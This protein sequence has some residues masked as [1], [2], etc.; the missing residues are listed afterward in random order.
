MVVVVSLLGESAPGASVRESEMLA[1]LAATADLIIT[2]SGADER[3]MFELLLRQAQAFWIEL[4]GPQDLDFLLA[5]LFAPTAGV[6]ML[7][8][9]VTGD[10]TSST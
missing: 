9:L 7:P 6:S 2:R 10:V 8:R 4:D 5:Q 1:S 3:E